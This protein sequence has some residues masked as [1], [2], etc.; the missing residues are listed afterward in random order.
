MDEANLRSTF[1]YL[2]SEITKRF[3][4]FAYLHVVEPRVEGSEDRTV[5]HGEVRSNFLSGIPMVLQDTIGN[6]FSARYL[7]LQAFHQ[8]GWLY[9]RGCNQHS[10]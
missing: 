5:Q 6:R 7:G 10:R 3:P 9:S 2:V 1:S 4:N 8:C